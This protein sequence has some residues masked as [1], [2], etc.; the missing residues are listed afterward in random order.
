MTSEP[1]WRGVAVA[2]VTLFDA[3]GAV[4]VPATAAHAA[5]LVDLGMRAVLVAGS[6]GEAEALTDPERLALVTAIRQACPGVPVIAGASGA[7]AAPVTEHVAASV[8]AGADA[9]LVAPPRRVGEIVGFYRTV[10]QSTGSRIPPAIRSGCCVHCRRGRD[11][12]MS[13]RPQWSATPAKW[14]PRGRYW[15]WRTP[16]PKSAWRP[17]MVTAP[18]SGG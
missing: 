16:Y 3:D 5:R 18:R 10:H 4:D 14:A 15:P 7:W 17:S 9:V 6:T 11:G 13:V 12:P 1:L 2:L 8:A